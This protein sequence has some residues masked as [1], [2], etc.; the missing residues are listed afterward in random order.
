MAKEWRPH[1]IS[2]VAIV[3]YLAHFWFQPPAGMALWAVSAV[4]AISSI[5]FGMMVREQSAD[6]SR[7]WMP[8][9][10]III[11][12]IILLGVTLSAI[13]LLAPQLRI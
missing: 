9:S 11:G 3:T 4:S 7:R 6:K 8:I 13:F 2:I 12:C 5:H 1:I 10:A